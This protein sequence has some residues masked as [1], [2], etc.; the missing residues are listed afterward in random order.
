MRILTLSIKQKYFDQILA[1]VKKVETREITPQNSNKYGV[2]M[3]E[4][5]GYA[6]YKN[7]PESILRDESIEINFTPTKYDALKLLTGEYKNKRPYLIVEVT[8]CEIF[9]EDDEEGN[10]I[11][12]ECEGEIFQ[13]A[14]IDYH[15][16]KII[17]VELYK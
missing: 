10:P 3:A 9:F 11:E 17:E 4:S 1:G 6:K 12:Y 5:K 15:L 8:G 16:G 7:I 2:Y 14:T 13:M